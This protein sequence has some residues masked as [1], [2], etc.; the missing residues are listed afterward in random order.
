MTAPRVD[1]GDPISDAALRV[2]RLSKTFRVPDDKVSTLKERVLHPVRSR[3]F[4]TFQA[5]SDVSFGVH[6]GECFG[7]IGRN[8]SGKST[9]L[10]C[11]SGIYR[12]DAGSV[13]ASGR[14]S[15]F[16]E[17]GVGFNP[18]L[19]AFDNVILNGALLGLTRK[20]ARDRY[21]QIMDF[22]E[23]WEFESVKLKNYSSGM[24][25][26]LAFAVM[27]Q[28]E[29]DI[30]VIDE[31]LAVGDAAFQRKCLESL[32]D[33]RHRGKTILLVTHD[34]DAVV[35]FCGRA[36]LLERGKVVKKGL[37]EEVARSYLE[38]NLASEVRPTDGRPPE[39]DDGV[40][41]GD[42][43]T[44]PAARLESVEIL[45]GEGAAH[46]VVTH[47]DEFQVSIVVRFA[48]QVEHPW[49]IVAVH[50]DDGTHVFS[51]ESTEQHPRP[52]V[53]QPGSRVRFTVKT[54]CPLIAGRY[55]V[56]VSCG[57]SE[58]YLHLFSEENA[59]EFVVTGGIHNGAILDLPKQ[60]TVEPA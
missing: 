36:M 34:M 28:I 3:R 33:L 18:E 1:Y 20:E 15:T 51:A 29:A 54:G 5:L 39:A 42:V 60:L 19:P 13:E 9:L 27:S 10:K 8:G 11:V 7:V 25:V 22:A 44:S 41:G 16:I 32:K 37:P 52:G 14:V 21:E 30:L 23:L 6:R 50:A 56:S 58:S 55:R 48:E 2:E 46:A 45:D 24:H 47:G 40:A 17:L 4:R 31:V 35:R 53:F 43:A 49:F 59:A 12:Q 57:R 26:R 38:L